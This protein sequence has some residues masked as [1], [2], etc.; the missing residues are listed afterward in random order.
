MARKNT[1]SLCKISKGISNKCFKPEVGPCLL[2]TYSDVCHHNITWLS[3]MSDSLNNHWCCWL[4]SHISGPQSPQRDGRQYV[5]GYLNTWFTISLLSVM[6]G[7]VGRSF[8]MTPCGRGSEALEWK[9]QL[10]ASHPDL[11]L[12]LS[13]M[14]TV[15]QLQLILMTVTPIIRVQEISNSLQS[16]PEI[17]GGKQ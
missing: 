14:N 9:W 5:Q 11:S 15:L 8:Q 12:W 17:A 6:H 2:F 16:F 13:E 10:P 7:W 3:H 4:L 1:C